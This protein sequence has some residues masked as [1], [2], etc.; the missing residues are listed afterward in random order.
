MKTTSPIEQEVNRIR[1][2]IREE[3]KDLTRKQRIERSNR[4]AEEA[5]KKYGIKIVAGT[6]K[7][8]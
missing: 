5:A 3:T 6:K 7:E 8:G 2:E 1:L 4:I